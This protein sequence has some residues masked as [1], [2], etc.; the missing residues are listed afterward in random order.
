MLGSGDGLLK[1]LWLLFYRL[2][3]KLVK[4]PRMPRSLSYDLWIQLRQYPRGIPDLVVFTR[5]CALRHRIQKG[6][7]V[8]CGNRFYVKSRGELGVASGAAVAFFECAAVDEKPCF[9]T[10]HHQENVSLMLSRNIRSA[11][12]ICKMA[13]RRL[14]DNR[15]I[16]VHQQRNDAIISALPR[17]PGKVS[18]CFYC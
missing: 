8:P 15:R 17:S 14:F 4:F 6:Y 1:G 10:L 11:E 2:T 5:C 16:R 12:L 3:E 13:G 18:N 9:H 7:E